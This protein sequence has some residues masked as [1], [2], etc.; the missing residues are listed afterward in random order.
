LRAR[1]D[2]VFITNQQTIAGKAR[3]ELS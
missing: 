1:A 3:K 2:L